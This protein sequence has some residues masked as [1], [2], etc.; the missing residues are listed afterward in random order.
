MLISNTVRLAIY[1]RRK[2]IAVMR[3]VGAS[4]WFIRFPFILE[5]TIQGLT[6]ALLAVIIIGLVKAALFAKVQ[7]SISFF[8]LGIEQ[9]FY[10]LLLLWL[11]VGGSAIG[12]IGST[13][14]LRR[15]LKV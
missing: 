2:E 8:P 5:G 12:A 1:A 3:L 11:L 15:Y 14:A 10:R 7:A 13:L 6:G 9:S 4:N